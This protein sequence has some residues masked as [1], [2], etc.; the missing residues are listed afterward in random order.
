[1]IDNV[2]N[3]TSGTMTYAWYKVIGRKDLSNNLDNDEL[4]RSQRPP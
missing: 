2:S 1:M 3:V 4:T